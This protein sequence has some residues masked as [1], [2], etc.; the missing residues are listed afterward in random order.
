MSRNASQNSYLSNTS[1]TKGNLPTTRRVLITC[2]DGYT[3]TSFLALAYII[4]ANCMYMEE[5]WLHLHRDKK[6][7]FYVFDHDVPS[8][9]AVFKALI[10]ASPH[11][12]AKRAETLKKNQWPWFHHYTS[13][14][15]F[16][17]N[18]PSRILPHLYLGNLEHANDITMLQKIGIE[19]V[20]SVGERTNP[21]MGAAGEFRASPKARLLIDSIQDDGID[22]LSNRI[23]ECLQFIDEGVKLGQATL[24]H[25]RVGVS[26]SASICIADVIRRLNLSLE[27]AY[28]LVRARRLNVIIQPNLRFMYELLRW[29]QEERS[30]LQGLPEGQLVGR[31]MEWASLST[32]IARLNKHYIQH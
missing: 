30:R 28:L 10:A 8:I 6:R 26:R 1:S 31:T 17:G 7:S 27:D 22:P 4:Y 13:A 20:L 16:K 15:R 32:K 24:V 21:M 2:K 14:R 19:R 5:A 29:S 11:S 18:F 12:A 25:C 3:E 9:M 23:E